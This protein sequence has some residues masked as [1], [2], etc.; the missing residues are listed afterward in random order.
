MTGEKTGSGAASDEAQGASPPFLAKGGELGALMR[1]HDWSTS[2]LGSPESWPQSLRTT[3]SLMLGSRFPMFLAWGQ[4][5]GFLYNDAYAPILGTK[6]PEALGRRF[7]DIWSDIWQD[8]KPFI[9]KALFGEAV[10]FENLPLTMHRN[11]YDE[12]AYFT[13]SYSPAYDDEGRVVGMFCA[14]TETTEK[15]LADQRLAAE[16]ERQRQ[17]FEQ[18]PGFITIL[19]GP[20]HVFEFANQAYSRLFGGR[21]FLGRTVREVFPDLAGQGFFELLDTVYTTGERFVAHDIPIRLQSLPGSPPEERFLDFIYEPVV[22]ETGVTG[23]FVEGYDTTERVRA[24]EARQ[25]SQQELQLL[26]DNL[27]VLIA[28]IDA[29]ARYRFLNRPYETWFLRRREDLLGRSVRDVVGEAA[30]AHVEPYIKKVLAGE[31]VTF[32]QFRPYADGV[33]RH[34][35]VEYVPRT[36][37][38]G[39]VEGF[40]SLVQEVSDSKRAEAALRASEARLAAIFAEAPVGLSEI[41]LDGRFQSVNSKLCSMLGRSRE[42]LLSGSIT[43]VTHQEDVALSREN[44]RRTIETGEPISFD[45]RYLRAD[46]MV[47]W[48]NSNLTR[49]DDAEGKPRGVLAVTVDLTDRHLQEAALRE[50][51]R[52]LETL[53]RTGATLAGELHVERLLQIV[54]DAAVELTG[55]KFG[56]YFHNVMDETGERLHLYTLSG[57]DRAAFESMGRPRATAIFGPTFRNETIIRSGDILA[58]ARYGHNAPH[59]GMPEGHLP[60]RSYL[61]IPVVSRSGEVLGGLIFGHPE[62]DRFSERHERLMTGL[63]AQAAIAID[64]A[65]LFQQVQAARE[66]LEQRVEERTAERNRIWSMSRDLFAVMG[67]DGYLKAINPAWETT[68]GFSVETLL[69]RPF[70]E[71]VHPDDHG[72]VEAAVEL[73]RRGETIARFEDRLRHADGSWRWI[74]WGLVPEGDVF[75]AVGRDITAEKEAA[76][77][78]EQAQEALRQSQKM[79][80]VGQLTGGLAHDFNNLLAGIS[81]SLELIGTRMAQGR[82][83]DVDR[84]LVA[85]QGAAKRAAALTHRL[86]AFS[87]RQTLDPKPTDVNRLVA[88]MEELIRRTVGPQVEIE[89]VAKAGL[90]SVL[91]DPHQLENSLLNLCINSRDAMPDGGKITIETGNR[92]LDERV[93]RERDLPPGQYVSLCVSDNGT[94]MTAEVIERAFDPFFTTKPIGVGTGLGLSMIYGFARQ[95]DGQV[96]IYSEVG[97]GTMVCIYLPR[98][99]NAETGADMPTAAS[100]VERAQAGETVLVIDDE[101]IVRMLVVDVL[102]ELGYAAIEASDGPE[103]LKVLRSDARVDL[104]I[105]DVG[106]PNGLNGRQVA[107]AA[108][109][110]R[111]DLRV[112]FVTGYAENAVLSHGHLDPGMEVVTKPFDLAVLASR[113]KAMTS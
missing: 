45:K 110:L 73:L 54:T 83:A 13:F 22:D 11:G 79:E 6:H 52:T 78:L 30:Y 66:T 101:P 70:P 42:E 57:A 112:L 85:A 14:C 67:F 24:E 36:A 92:W 100:S 81:G 99:H 12:Q 108:R 32:E 18:A 49:L 35:R 91:V 56:A 55:A 90:W 37:P 65:R 17:Q 2:P 102:Q 43:G 89:A 58:D 48:A 63:A 39:H 23:I 15:V 107:D 94:G 82:L 80:A 40:Y 72:A 50:E 3:V 111:P 75:Y 53:N 109:Q 77:E 16:R 95:S 98:H 44:L 8:I 96:R 29:D 104:L 84:Y 61:A 93:G 64:N 60:V 88:G 68:L 4:D 74:A 9:D 71:Q 21:D 47:V 46:G 59:R 51:T 33:S 26:T 103:G 34:V 62:A 19:S 41:G 7:A 25:H 97:Q 76:A 20:D 87:R 10:W 69:T 105:T 5:L 113:I 28:Y 31:R 27:P 38:D 106:L 86:L 1:A